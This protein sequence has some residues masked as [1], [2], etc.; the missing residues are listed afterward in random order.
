MPLCAVMALHVCCFS[1]MSSH[2]LVPAQATERRS[3]W[4]GREM[5]TFSGACMRNHARPSLLAVTALCLATTVTILC[6]S[7]A[8]HISVS[9]WRYRKKTGALYRGWSQAHLQHRWSTEDRKIW[10]LWMESW[11]KTNEDHRGDFS[12]KYHFMLHLN[13]KPN[14]LQF[15]Y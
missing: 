8:V 3:C 15:I 5:T 6:Q 14:C 9:G 11:H 7:T 13:I 1:C 2:S 12:F 10:F 4:R